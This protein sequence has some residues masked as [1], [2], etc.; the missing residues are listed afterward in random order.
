MG[1]TYFAITFYYLM[2]EYR[3][4]SRV[5]LLLSPAAAAAADLQRQ[6][7]IQYEMYDCI[8]RQNYKIFT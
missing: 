2:F 8:V 3:A 5:A 7:K 6:N 4:V 1:K